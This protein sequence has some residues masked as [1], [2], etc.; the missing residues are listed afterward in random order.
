VTI[1]LGRNSKSMRMRI[2]QPYPA[3]LF[4]A[5]RRLQTTS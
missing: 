4:L 1:G 5:A 3:F 2:A